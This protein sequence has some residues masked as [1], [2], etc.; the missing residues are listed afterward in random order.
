MHVIVCIDGKLI[1]K[2]MGTRSPT[3]PPQVLLLQVHQPWCQLT[4][5]LGVGKILSSQ[6]TVQKCRVVEPVSPVR[7]HFFHYICTSW[8]S[9]CD[10]TTSAITLHLTNEIIHKNNFKTT[11][12]QRNLVPFQAPCTHSSISYSPVVIIQRKPHTLIMC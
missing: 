1:M 2:G 11:T 12:L 5:N 8:E 7:F 3:L 6:C 9:P 4:S 10:S